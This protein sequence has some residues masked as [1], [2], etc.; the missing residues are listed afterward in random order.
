MNFELT[1]D[2]ATICIDDGKAN[3]VSPALVEEM[4]VSLDR[5]KTEAKAIVLIGRAGMFSAGF[6]L[7][8]LQQGPEVAGALVNGGMEVLTG[9]YS[10]PQPVIAACGGHAIGMGAFILLASD[11]RLGSDSEYNVTL[12]ETAIGMPFTPVLMTLIKERLSNRHKS[13]AVLQSKPHSPVEAVDAGFLDRI[14]AADSLVTEAQKLAES[15]AQLPAQVYAANKED[16]RSQSL[17]TMRDSL[18]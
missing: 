4:L 1:N 5:A 6:D 10:H 11:Y 8:A 18:S 12:P 2:I 7:K 15:L 3:V 13:I 9:L 17:A 16:L 14:V